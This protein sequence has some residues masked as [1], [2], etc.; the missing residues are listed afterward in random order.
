MPIAPDAAS[1]IG[2]A[3]VL[4]HL[5]AYAALGTFLVWGILAF[6]WRTIVQLRRTGDSGLRLHAEP[7]T[8][9]WWAKIGFVVAIAGGLA[10]PIAA[11]AGLDDVD[12][13]DSSVLHVAGIAVAFVGVALTL[14]AQLAMGESWRIGVDPHE[15]TALV[16]DG[17][18]GLV[19]NPIFT[20]MLVTVIGL[21]MMIPNPVSIIGLVALVT[22]LGVQVRLVEEPY[23]TTVHGDRYLTYA[24]CVGRFVPG[25]GR[26]A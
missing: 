25:L 15:Q 11:V 19:R 7:N 3:L 23:L 16:T 14:G 18:F 26:L 13:F 2:P 6:G 17:P 9:Q 21:A 10:A 12:G 8:P 5:M 24:R 20:A 4:C 22:A 1:A